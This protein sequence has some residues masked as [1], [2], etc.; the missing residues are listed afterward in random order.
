MFFQKRIEIECLLQP[1]PRR[2]KVWYRSNLND[3]YA[4]ITIIYNI[5][6]PLIAYCVNPLARSVHFE[7]LMDKYCTDFGVKEHSFIVDQKARVFY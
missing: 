7:D 1:F 6:V 2:R 5:L 3:R 4:L